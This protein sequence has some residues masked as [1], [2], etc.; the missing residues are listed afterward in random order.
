MEAQ[1]QFAA[2]QEERHRLDAQLADPAM[3]TRPDVDKLK[4]L[5]RRQQQLGGLIEAAEARWLAAQTEL[6]AIGEV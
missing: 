4:A 3:Y 5:S 6:E 1:A 2:W